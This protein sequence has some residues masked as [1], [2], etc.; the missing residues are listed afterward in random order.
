MKELFIHRI[1]E[2]QHLLTAIIG[3]EGTDISGIADN[4]KAKGSDN[5]QSRS[6]KKHQKKKEERRSSKKAAT[7]G[8]RILASPLA[9]K[10][11]NDKGIQL[12]QVKVQ[13]KM[14]V[15]LRAMS[16]T[17]L[18]LQQYHLLQRKLLSTS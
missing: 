14:D 18:Q 3:P 15:S 7:D 6:P 12:T 5:L 11:A 9:K 8:Q 2:M 17:L 13:V 4:Y 10:I 1:Q 16:K